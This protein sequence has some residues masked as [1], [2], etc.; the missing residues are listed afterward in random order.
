MIR[1]A[2]SF[3]LLYDYMNYL[4]FHVNLSFVMF[5]STYQL[6]LLHFFNSTASAKV[7]IHR[8]G[9]SEPSHQPTAFDNPHI[10]SSTLLWYV[11]EYIYIFL[12][13]KSVNFNSVLLGSTGGVR[14]SVAVRALSITKASHVRFPDSVSYVGRVVCRFSPVLRGF[15]W[16]LR[17]FLPPQKSSSKFQ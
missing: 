9:I 8:Q 2:S 10:E 12:Y 3:L 1:L 15:I 13:A 7:S 16:V 11:G 4:W 6:K 14:I 5:Y 17:F